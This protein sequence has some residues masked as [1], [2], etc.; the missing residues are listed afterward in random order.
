[1]LVMLITPG[2][3]LGLVVDPRRGLLFWSEWSGEKRS[4][5][6]K[7]NTIANDDSLSP[8]ILC[9]GLD[10]SDRRV[11]V[12][13]STKLVY[14]PHP[15]S[16]ASASPAASLAPTPFYTGGKKFRRIWRSKRSMERK[17]HSDSKADVFVS[18]Q[19]VRNEQRSIRASTNALRFR[20]SITPLEQHLV[21]P[22]G[23][24]LDS[25]DGR[26]FF[27][28]FQLGLIG[29]L[30][31]M[32]TRPQV[33]VVLAS[34]AFRPYSL[35]VFEDRVYWSDWRKRAVLSANKWNG[36]DAGSAIHTWQI[37][38]G[39]TPSLHSTL[40]G[41]EKRESVT[42]RLQAS[43][44]KALR[45]LHSLA[46]PHDDRAKQ[47]CRPPQSASP[48]LAPLLSTTEEQL[49]SHLCLPRGLRPGRPVSVGEEF[50]WGVELTPRHSCAC[51][52]LLHLAKDGRT[53]LT[54]EGIPAVS[55]P[56]DTPVHL[57]RQIMLVTA[58]LFVSLVLGVCLSLLLAH[59]HRIRCSRACI[60]GETAVWQMRHC[61]SVYHLSGTSLSPQS[62]QQPHQPRSQASLH[63]SHSGGDGFHNLDYT[64]FC[65]FLSNSAKSNKL[66]SACPCRQRTPI[67]A[68]TASSTAW[69][70]CLT[71]RKGRRVLRQFSRL[72]AA[73]GDKSNQYTG[74]K[75][76]MEEKRRDSSDSLSIAVSGICSPP[77]VL[78]EGKFYDNRDLQAVGLLASES[79]Q[80]NGQKIEARLER[81]D[82]PDEGFVSSFQLHEP[83][84]TDKL[85]FPLRQL[86]S[87]NRRHSLTSL[88]EQIAWAPGLDSRCVETRPDLICSTDLLRRHVH[89][90]L[91]PTGNHNFCHQSYGAKASDL[92]P[93]AS[94]PLNLSAPLPLLTQ[95]PPVSRHSEQGGLTFSDH[96]SQVEI[97][98]V[99]PVRQVLSCPPSP[100]VACKYMCYPSHLGVAMSSITPLRS[101]SNTIERPARSVLF[102]GPVAS[103]GIGSEV[104][105]ISSSPTP[106]IPIAPTFRLN[107]TMAK[108][109]I[110]LDLHPDP[111]SKTSSLG[112]LTSKVRESLGAMWR[113][114]LRVGQSAPPSSFLSTAFSIWNSNATSH[115]NKSEVNT[116]L[117]VS[118]LRNQNSPPVMLSDSSPKVSSLID[119]QLA[120]T[121]LELGFSFSSFGIP[122][123]SP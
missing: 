113:P 105:T 6:A 45:M 103:L 36:K 10:G 122:N 32:E 79:Y 64:A 86:E 111:R 46:Q 71:Y 59:R 66:S 25:V 68:D 109:S 107:R 1:M 119:S 35:A 87:G 81:S 91:Q 52:D 22:S 47:W 95:P 78:Q 16:H 123:I 104:V 57:R 97:T 28:D 55:G 4:V 41:D 116:I 72:G 121:N 85:V 24:A 110:N 53:C 3:P 61:D 21:A 74:E 9:S 27:A 7:A 31:P 49:C 82:E 2:I 75:G 43:L 48:L 60:C 99:C 39:S 8:R 114:L 94:L 106:T 76:E 77:N 23:L 69:T 26:L 108:V 73:S 102:G 92:L 88:A 54:A 58:C 50:T 67:H 42:S 5:G 84:F 112:S 118:V 62:P 19:Q 30:D 33:H 17:F 18:G 38:P 63:T 70:S 96:S 56:F 65:L 117:P 90:Q 120:Q 20:R 101:F 15:P 40:G 29:S 93:A 44:P 34:T 100:R 98:R 115:A 51:P 13:S 80:E 37:V 14:S 12:D 89:D 83:I 11:L